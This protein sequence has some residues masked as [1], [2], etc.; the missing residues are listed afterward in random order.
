MHGFGIVARER[1][2]LVSVAAHEVFEFFM[3]NTGEDG[4]IGDLVAVEVEDG[5]H[6]AVGGGVEELVGVPAGG[7][8]AGF[9]F[10][11]ADDAGDDEVGVVEG[12]AVGVDQGIAELAAFVNGAG[13]FRRDVAGDAVGPAELAEEALDAVAILFDVGIDLGV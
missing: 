6:G 1:E 10:A 5:E 4:G 9:R 8:G 3:G 2:G 12:G 11:V 7:E 13:G